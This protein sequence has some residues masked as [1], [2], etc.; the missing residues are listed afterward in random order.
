M[1]PAATKQIEELKKLLQINMDL[2]MHLAQ[3]DTL[4]SLFQN[5]TIPGGI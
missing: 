4:L 1:L 2:K 3:V 5:E